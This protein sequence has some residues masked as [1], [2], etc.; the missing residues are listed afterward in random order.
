MYPHWKKNPESEVEWFE[1]LTALARYL[2]LPEG[3]PWDREQGS[4]EFAHFAREE[5]DELIEA[6][7]S[8][9][10]SHI[11]EEFG[12]ALFCLL[13]TAAAAEEEGRFTL[14]SALIRIHDKMIR[15]HDHVFGDDKAVSP[16]EAIERWNQVK[17]AEK[18]AKNQNDS[19]TD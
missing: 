15:R 18:K 17:Q 10:N 19:S 2:R 8:D 1:G 13:A 6:F 7:A 3:C 5:C 4:K 9:D 12:D 14:E 16:E 11:E